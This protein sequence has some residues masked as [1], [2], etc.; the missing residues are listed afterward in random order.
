MTGTAHLPDWRD[1][2]VYD[3]IPTLGRYALAWELLRRD[4]V[5]RRFASAN[6]LTPAMS[7]GVPDASGNWGL[8]FP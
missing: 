6:A 1:R 7:G 8:H 3:V 5:Y 4:S 2:A